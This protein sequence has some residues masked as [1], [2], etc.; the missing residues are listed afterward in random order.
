M[1]YKAY[2]PEGGDEALVVTVDQY[3]RFHSLKIGTPV[4]SLNNEA[5][6]ARRATLQGFCTIKEDVFPLVS[7]ADQEDSFISFATLLHITPNT[8]K[9]LTDPEEAKRVWYTG[10]MLQ[11]TRI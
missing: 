3:R 9:L 5:P 10:M 8:V 1:T 11:A 7:Y 4:I 6:Y 2:F